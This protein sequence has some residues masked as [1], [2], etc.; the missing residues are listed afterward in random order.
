MPIAAVQGATA[1]REDISRFVVH[2][3]RDDRR[4]FTGGQ[5]AR[6]NFLRIMDEE[7]IIAYRPHCLHGKQIPGLSDELQQ[8]FNVACFTEVPLSQLKHLIREIP[9]RQVKLE[10]YG[11]V[12][13]RNFLIGKGAQPAIYI[14]SYGGNAYLRESVD[15]IWETA[16]KNKFK[17]RIWRL[18]PFVNAMHEK[19]DFTW[20]REWRV[21]GELSFEMD[22][23]VCVI[24]PPVGNLDIRERLAKAGIAAISPEWGYERIISELAKQQRKTKLILDGLLKKKPQPKISKGG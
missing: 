18:L 10:P 15:A 6:D 19:Y 23:V 9:G 4:D 5:P 11:F 16:K 1:G 2:L 22:D 24:L 17:G 13:T 20:E 14:N 3:T 21:L 8:S 7:R 12:F